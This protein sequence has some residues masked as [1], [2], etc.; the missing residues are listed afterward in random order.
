[1]NFAEAIKNEQKWTL[2]ENG[3]VALNTT[4]TALLDLFSTVGALRQRAAV[5]IETMVEEAYKENPL[6]TVKCLFYA[7]DV[8]EGL[9]ERD[10]FRVALNYLAKH[11]PEAVKENIKLISEYGRWDDIYCLVGTPCEDKM[12]AVVNEQFRN[13]IIKMN[14]DKPISLLAKWLKSVD[15][16][17]EES[18]KLG[19]LTAEKLGLVNDETGW[20]R[21]TPYRFYLKTMRSYIKVVE[22]KMCSRDWGEIKY[23]EVPSR[24]MK[25]YGNAF[26]KHDEERYKEFL[27]KV[28][29][30]EA[31][32]NA[33][34]LY[35]YDLIREY[36][37]SKSYY[38][39]W[40]EEENPTVEALWANL[41]N[42][43][44]P[45]TNAVVI[46]DTSGSMSFNSN[47]RPMDSAVGL[48]IYFAQRNTGAYHGLWMNFSTNPSWQKIKG[49][50]LYQIINNMNMDNWNGSTDL[51]AA[52][53]LVLET[54]INNGVSPAEM[55]KSLIVISDM[56]IDNCG[57]R[58]WTFYDKMR[59]EFA[60]HGYEIPQI[61][62]WN[63]N[64]RNNVFHADSSR[65]GVILCSGNSTT[66][67]KTL[68]GSAGMTPVEYMNSV[69]GSK[70]YEAVKIA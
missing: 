4:G 20:K 7:R 22:K 2:T 6:D 54:A 55:P 60:A 11:H 10:T 8:R 43:V 34:T 58:D 35:P 63:V 25:L 51:C 27:N 46:A 42:Y 28:N 3:A 45:G 36:R 64:S 33:S 31:K 32:I 65:K 23:D 66:T 57:N 26:S 17:S 62:F 9:G 48:A 49:T 47:G 38:V 39:N 30:G 40:S 16:S 41:P 24:A 13:D 61:I 59:V 1:M 15:T 52:F 12:W 67:F 18:K 50:K 68:I 53:R 5:D 37:N 56:E 44:A 14:N 69:L 19:R 29:T 21:Y 70:R